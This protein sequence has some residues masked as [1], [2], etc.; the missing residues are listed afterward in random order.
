M[1]DIEADVPTGTG[2][3]RVIGFLPSTLMTFCLTSVE[4]TYSRDDRTSAA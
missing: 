2:F 3:N 1:N 4:A